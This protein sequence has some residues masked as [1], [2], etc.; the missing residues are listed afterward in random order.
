MKDQFEIKGDNFISIFHFLDDQ[1]KPGRTVSTAKIGD[2][3]MTRMIIEP[4]VVVSNKYHKETRRMFYVERGNVYAVFEQVNTKKRKEMHIKPDKHAIHVP[5]Y[6][7]MAMKNM[8][9]EEAVLVFF[10]NNPLR[11]E[12]NFDYKLL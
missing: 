5:E 8:G 3:Y 4:G 9:K 1:S 7:A 6:V 2:I 10:S 11:S 12:D